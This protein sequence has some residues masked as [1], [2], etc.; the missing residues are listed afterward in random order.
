MAEKNEL[1]EQDFL[2]KLECLASLGMTGNVKDE[3]PFVILYDMVKLRRM[4]IEAE[5]KAN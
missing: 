3:M 5:G 4:E 2:E 1:G